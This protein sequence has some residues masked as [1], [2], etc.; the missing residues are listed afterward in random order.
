M[1]RR[2]IPFFRPPHLF[3][4]S[5]LFSFGGHLLIAWASLIVHE[6]VREKLRSK[7]GDVA[8]FFIGHYVSKGS[9]LFPGE[10]LTAPRVGPKH[11]RTK[12]SSLKMCPLLPLCVSRGNSTDLSPFW[13]PYNATFTW[14]SFVR[15]KSFFVDFRSLFS[16]GKLAASESRNQ[17]QH[18]ISSIHRISK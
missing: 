5:K 14:L 16:Q 18:T 12:H 15:L 3:D 1:D 11:Q 6:R 13:L 8:I 2:D 9:I 17:S 7:H 4:S 10:T